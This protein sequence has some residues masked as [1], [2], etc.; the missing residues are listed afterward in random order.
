MRAEPPVAFDPLAHRVD[1]RARACQRLWCAVL[2]AAL[3]DEARAERRWAVKA[4][5]GAARRIASWV[6]S[7]DF[8]TV[9]ALAG[10][11]GPAVLDRWNAGALH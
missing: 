3:E 9:C 6:G 8:F 7:R 2:L 11:D 4:R 10:V 5:G 1:A